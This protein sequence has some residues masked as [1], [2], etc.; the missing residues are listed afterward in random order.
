MSR[1]YAS[2]SML[3]A[4][5]LIL[6]SGPL[7][8]QNSPFG[9]F[10]LNFL[11][12]SS[13][14]GLIWIANG[15]L[16]A[17]ASS[18]VLLDGM[19]A[20]MSIQTTGLEP[21]S[22]TTVWWLIFN[23]PRACASTPCTPDDFGNAETKSSVLWATGEIA[24]EY[25]QADFAAHLVRGLPPTGEVLFGPGLTARFPEIQLVVRTHGP[26]SDLSPEQ[27]EAALTSFNGACDINA[28][29]DLQIAF[30]LR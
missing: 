12:R 30:H 26:A 22:A 3:L 10:T 25:G 27:L 4:A 1:N 6:L 21:R 13:S 9:S 23:N 7:I 19:G 20:S 24:D 28:C 16:V 2:H 5:G 29:E 11:T 18:T 15:D 8:A 14:A 17:R